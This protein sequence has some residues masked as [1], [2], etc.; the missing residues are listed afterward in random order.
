M[1]AFFRWLRMPVQHVIRLSARTFCWQLHRKEHYS[2]V[3]E[4][5]PFITKTNALLRV[6]WCTKKKPKKKPHRHWLQRHGKSTVWSDE[7]FFTTFSTCGLVQVW[8]M[9][10]E[11]SWQISA[12]WFFFICDETFQISWEYTWSCRIIISPS[13]G[14]KHLLN[15]LMSKKECKSYAMMFTH[16]RSQPNWTSHLWEDINKIVK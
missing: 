16:T 13:T 1:Q 9:S 4:H 15:N 11:Q 7:S 10:G 3:A 6:Q 8:H 2:R 12:K 5:K 14:H